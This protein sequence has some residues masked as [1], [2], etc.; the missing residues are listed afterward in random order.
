MNM[1]TADGQNYSV[2][3]IT[4]AQLRALVF[5]NGAIPAGL[6]AGASITKGIG[7]PPAW[8]EFRG[9]ALIVA[10]AD[11]NGVSGICVRQSQIVAVT[12]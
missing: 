12:P 11:A 8:I 2:M 6:P 9:N 7:N 1:S 3:G 5:E 10:P 4:Y